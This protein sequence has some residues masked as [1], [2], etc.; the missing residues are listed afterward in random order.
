MALTGLDYFSIVTGLA[1]LYGAYE[2][3]R[4]RVGAKRERL[5]AVS[6]EVAARA[7]SEAAAMA[8]FQTRR[9]LEGLDARRRLDAARSAC[10]RADDAIRD[11]NYDR[12]RTVLLDALSDVTHLGAATWSAEL[13]SAMTWM[14][15]RQTLREVSETLNVLSA[16]G[17][18][19]EARKTAAATV[20]EVMMQLDEIS[21]KAT[22]KIGVGD[23]HPR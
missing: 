4:Q 12:A 7:F 17:L 21:A 9:L 1:S 19:Q 8:A 20:I 13:A 10:R 6:A 3:R 11:A 23:A 15:L 18:N 5:A 16:C 22:S 14:R 2:S